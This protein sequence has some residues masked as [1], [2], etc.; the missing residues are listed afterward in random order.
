MVETPLAF[1]PLAG[2]AGLSEG[3]EGQYGA[4]WTDK[5]CGY[6]NA[7]ALQLCHSTT[8]VTLALG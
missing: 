6:E 1:Q 4:R 8:G 2:P 7:L 5:V 3:A